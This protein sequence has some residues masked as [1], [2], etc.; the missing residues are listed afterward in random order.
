MDT[1]YI[2]D[3]VDQ[4]MRE[5]MMM[6]GYG[7]PHR[8]RDSKCT[9]RSKTGKFWTD[10]YNK[11]KIKCMPYATHLEQMKKAPAKKRKAPVKRRKTSSYVSPLTGRKLKYKLGPK[12]TRC[13]SKCAKL[14]SKRS[15]APCMARC[16]RTYQ[17]AGCDCEACGGVM[18]GG[19]P[20]MDF[21]REFREYNPGMPQSE[22]LRL[23]SEEYNG[24]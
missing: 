3:R 24:Y 14:K 1:N 16:S 10:W 15:R 5:K 17:G 23:A 19:N 2:R 4:I 12:T 18:V 7:M 22:V 20:W 9:K 8:F 13:R 21:L 6:G 11:K